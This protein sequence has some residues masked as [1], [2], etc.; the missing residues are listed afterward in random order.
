MSAALKPEELPAHLDDGQRRLYELIWRRAMASQG[1]SAVYE[2]A[3]DC[4]CDRI[5]LLAWTVVALLPP[6]CDP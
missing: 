4:S 6:A 5:R 3:S 1:S 2:Q